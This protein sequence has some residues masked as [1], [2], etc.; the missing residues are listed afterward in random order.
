MSD[1]YIL[2]HFLYGH[3]VYLNSVMWSPVFTHWQSMFKCW[4]RHFIPIEHIVIGMT[5]H[6][7]IH[8]SYFCKR[9]IFSVH[10]CHEFF[11]F[12]I[13]SNISKRLNGFLDK[14]FST[15]S[16]I[17]LHMIFLTT[18]ST[19]QVSSAALL[20][21]SHDSDIWNT[22]KG[23]ELYCLTLDCKSNFYFFFGLRV[24]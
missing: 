23:L 13:Y 22:S 20:V 4:P 19:Y 2:M 8:F 16:T 9:Y 5:F 24:Y 15:M 18:F 12:F 17:F 11:L 6:I 7:W 1:Y 14:A 21:N 3:L 10:H